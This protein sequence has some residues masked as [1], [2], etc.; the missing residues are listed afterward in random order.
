M[1]K[2]IG[3]LLLPALAWL[4]AAEPAPARAA[5]TKI[6][7]IA[8][9]PS[10]GPGA[11][12]FNAGTKLLVKCLKETPGIEPVFVAGGWPSD[13]GV[14]QGAKAV[15]FFMD[16]GGNH[17]MIQ[18][19]RLET[20][21]RLM[22]EG[23]GLVCLHYAVE[24]PKGKPGDAFLDWL[25]GYYETGYS[26]NPHWTADIKTLPDHPIT[27]GVHPFSINDEWYYNMRFRPD[28]K[29]VTPIVVAKPDD[30]TRKGTSSSPRGPYPHVVAASGRDEVLAWA[31]ERPDGGRGFGFTGA[32]FH[33]N[34][35]NPDFRT[36]VL[37]AIVWSAKLDVPSS[38]VQ[39][40]VSDEELEKNLDPKPAPKAKTAT[41]KQ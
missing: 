23:V 10:H 1:R 8:G 38:G 12:E 31:V 20:M 3:L 25:G 17:P 4:G 19:D 26:T 34:W 7:L 14:F 28:M 11:H 15:V 37:N 30:A 13:E 24:V 2:L 40:N 21:R 41:K 36:L 22:A 35:G 39:C 16:G 29:G 9:K 32:H 18:G 27:R 6:V 5:D 33:K